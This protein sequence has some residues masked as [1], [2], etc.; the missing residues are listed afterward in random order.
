[1]QNVDETERMQRQVAALS[2][3][4]VIKN[5]GTQTDVSMTDAAQQTEEDLPSMLESFQESNKKL[6]E[7][8]FGISMIEGND[9]ATKFYT[10]LPNW[11]VF[12]HLFMFLSPFVVP[13]CSLSYHDEMLLVLVKLR[14]NLLTVDLAYRCGISAGLVSRVFQKWLD[15]MCVRLR[16]LITWP[17]REIL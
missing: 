9:T 11:S 13:S 2:E 6:K 12:L 3:M 10:G 7:K 4:E 16:F 1:M 17:S 15:V 14:L 8:S 5:E